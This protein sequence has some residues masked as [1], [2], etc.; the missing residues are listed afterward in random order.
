MRSLCIAVDLQEAVY[1]LEVLSV[2]MEMRQWVP[3][4]LL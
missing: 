1:D 4:E 3:F 2:A